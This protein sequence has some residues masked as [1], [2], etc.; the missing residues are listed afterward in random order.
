MERAQ[1]N[2]SK[3]SV[4]HDRFSLNDLLLWWLFVLAVVSY[5]LEIVLLLLLSCGA[6]AAAWVPLL[7]F[8]SF[9]LLAQFAKRKLLLYAK[10]QYPGCCWNFSKGTGGN[11]NGCRSRGTDN[12]TNDPSAAAAGAKSATPH[13][14]T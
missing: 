7:R 10:R 3:N 13:V 12:G 4:H 5:H 9:F 14:L 11:G 8:F 1:L 6:A 2:W